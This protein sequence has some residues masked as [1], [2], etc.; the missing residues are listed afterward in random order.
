MKA[1]ITVDHGHQ[2]LGTLHLELYE[3]TVPKTVQNFAT[4]LQRRDAA[5]RACYLGSTFHRI[6]PGF[7]AQGGDFTAGDGTGGMSI[8]GPVFDDENFLRQHSRAGI[9]SMAN[10]TFNVENEQNILIFASI[11]AL[12]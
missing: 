6:I 3:E 12:T 10:G 11:L 9:L 7:M 5:G 2:R 4:L 1:F 8:Y